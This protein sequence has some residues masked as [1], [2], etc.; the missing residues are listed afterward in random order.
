MKNQT[1]TCIVR[2]L[3]KIGQEAFLLEKLD[4][5]LDDTKKYEKGC[6]ET[7]LMVNEKKEQEICMTLSFNDYEEYRNHFKTAH[8]KDFVEKHAS[9]LVQSIDQESYRSVPE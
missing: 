5:L 3:S 8:L 4:K 6:F 1:L 2:F 7:K 9:S